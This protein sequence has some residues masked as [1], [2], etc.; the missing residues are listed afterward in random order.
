MLRTR[1]KLGRHAPMVRRDSTRRGIQCRATCT[2]R[3]REGGRGGQRTSC[4]SLKPKRGAE[5]SAAT[6]AGA[7]IVAQRR[8]RRRKGA[9]GA[10]R[11]ERSQQRR[12]QA[13]G[14]TTS[15]SSCDAGGQKYRREHQAGVR[16]K[17]RVAAQGQPGDSQAARGHAPK[18]AQQARRESSGGGVLA[19]ERGTPFTVA[20]GPTRRGEGSENPREGRR[21]FQ[22]PSTSRGWQVPHT[23]FPRVPGAGREAKAAESRSRGAKRPREPARGE[24]GGARRERAGETRREQAGAPTLACTSGPKPRNVQRRR[25]AMPRALAV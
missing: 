16:P 15:K 20:G 13:S 5:E 12:Q 2:R 23:G 4:T 17:G 3:R 7:A 9:R 8:E 21:V 6:L 14:G 10:R 1:R 11:G 18:Q 24:R 22:R 19:Q 25:G